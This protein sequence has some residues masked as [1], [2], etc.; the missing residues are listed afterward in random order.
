MIAVGAL[1]T[2]SQPL[3]P[4]DP[5]APVSPFGPRGTGGAGIS[6]RAGRSGI[7]LCTRCAGL[8]LRALRTGRERPA[9]KSAATSVPSFTLRPVT[10]PFFS[11]PAPTEFFG[12]TNLAAAW[13]SG[14]DPSTATTRAVTATI[15]VVLRVQ[16]CEDS[17]SVGQRLRSGTLPRAVASR[18][19]RRRSL[20]GGRPALRVSVNRRPACRSSAASSRE[21]EALGALGSSTS[22]S[23]TGPESR[24]RGESAI[25]TRPESRRSRRRSPRSSGRPAPSSPGLQ[26]PSPARGSRT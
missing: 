22:A 13:L 14:V 15:I 5:A 25:A 16:H 4:G 21:R 8:A 12:R 9:L 18:N 7:A 20:R 24:R 23:V 10:A 17:C 6:L 3:T 11:W 26:R 2:F 19:G 1:S